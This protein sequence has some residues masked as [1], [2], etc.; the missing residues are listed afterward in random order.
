[1]NRP[2]NPPA[3]WLSRRRFG[4]LAGLAVTVVAGGLGSL[5]GYAPQAYAAGPRH[6]DFDYEPLHGC[7]CH[8]GQPD[9]TCLG[10]CSA[11]ESHCQWGPRP[12]E[13][14]CIVYNFNPH[15]H[16]LARAVGSCTAASG[17]GYCC[18]SY[19]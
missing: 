17:T 5:V 6:C 14:Y 4:K 13:D 2:S 10:I 12:N 16:P 7:Q 9:C 18:G 3:P 8:P 11:T 1:V 19:C 15:A